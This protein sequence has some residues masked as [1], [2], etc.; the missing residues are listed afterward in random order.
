MTTDIRTKASTDAYRDGWDR[1]FR[2][3]PTCDCVQHRHIDGV[4]QNC[5]KDNLGLLLDAIQSARSKN[6]E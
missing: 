5:G 2:R 4:C 6:T 3:Q 1:I